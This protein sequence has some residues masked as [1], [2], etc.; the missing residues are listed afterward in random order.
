MLL[1]AWQDKVLAFASPLEPLVLG[2][3]LGDVGFSG[4][5]RSYTPLS[6]ALPTVEALGVPGPSVCG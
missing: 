6:Y 3:M 2:L 4:E 1:E 5:I